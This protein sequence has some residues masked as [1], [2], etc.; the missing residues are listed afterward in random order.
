M[1]VEIKSGHTGQKLYFKS[2]SVM[3]GMLLFMITE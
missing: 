2:Y 1:G 3:G